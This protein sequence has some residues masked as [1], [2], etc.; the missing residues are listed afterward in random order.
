M[1]GIAAYKPVY[2]YALNFGATT[3][4][5]SAYVTLAAAVAKP[6]SAVEIFNPSGATLIIA[7]GAAS[8]EVPY[9]YYILPGG[10]SIFLPMEIAAGVR[11]SLKALTSTS[12]TN[13]YFV[14]NMF[15]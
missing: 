8:S 14:L 9:P 5:N 4:D 1:R 12:A 2:T 13:G 10:S 6:C 3:V 15:G 7:A 11:L